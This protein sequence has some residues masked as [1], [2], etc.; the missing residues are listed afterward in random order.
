MR[1]LVVGDIHGGL[2]AL[3]A[4]LAE[5][6]VRKDD[7]IVFLGDY[8]DG[9]SQSAETVDYLIGFGARHNCVFLRGNHDD[10]CLDWLKAGKEPDLW[11]HSGGFATQASYKGI[12]ARDRQ[13][14]IRFLEELQDY[15][16]DTS[17]RLFLHAGFTNQR[18]VQHEYFAKNFYWDRT[19]WETALS[20]NP[21]L[22][23]GDLKYPSRLKHYAEIYIGHTPVSRIGTDQPHRAANV[24]NVDTGAAFRGPLSILDAE[25]K[26]VW[27]SEAVHRLYPGEQGRN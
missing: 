25:T 21:K 17:N 1:K 18:G 16:L 20:L 9:W 26:Q 2:R 23:P 15:H 14:H 3:E 11:L 10:L 6:G 24:W 27:Q 19:L 7:F 13:R 12:G 4:V 5:C 22:E 8:V